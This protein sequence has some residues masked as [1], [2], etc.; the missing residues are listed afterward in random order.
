MFITALFAFF[1][2]KAVASVVAPEG[3]IEREVRPLPRR[4]MVRCESCG[5]YVLRERAL[6]R[7]GDVFFCS[8]AC[9]SAA[10]R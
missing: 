3:A 2:T 1:F 10:A 8:G 5:V 9:S 7:G 4:Q 6:S